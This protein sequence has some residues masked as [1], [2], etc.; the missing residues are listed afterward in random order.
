MN[1]FQFSHMTRYPAIFYQQ[2]EQVFHFLKIQQVSTNLLE[3]FIP[4]FD[5]V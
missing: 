4:H 1:F 5:K 3:N 2:F